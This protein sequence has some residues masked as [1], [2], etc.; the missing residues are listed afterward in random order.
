MSCQFGRG[1]GV[2]SWELR[3]GSWELGVGSWELGVGSWEL[4]VGKMPAFSL[5]PSNPYSLFPI[6]Y[7]LYPLTPIP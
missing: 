6:P 1:L 3:V 2:R 5:L 7:S 4:E